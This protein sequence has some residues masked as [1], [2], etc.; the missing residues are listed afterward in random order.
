MFY[1]YT[2]KRKFYLLSSSQR[3][4]QEKEEKNKKNQVESWLAGKPSGYVMEPFN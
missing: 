2:E 3:K 1:V 4:E